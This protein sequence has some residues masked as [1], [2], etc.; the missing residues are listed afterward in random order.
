M[1]GGLNITDSYKEESPSWYRSVC[2]IPISRVWCR[3]CQHENQLATRPGFM[4]EVCGITGI[5]ANCCPFVIEVNNKIQIGHNQNKYRWV[6]RG[7]LTPKLERAIDLGQRAIDLGQQRQSQC[8]ELYRGHSQ[9][10]QHSAHFLCRSVS[11]SHLKHR[12]LIVRD[13]DLFLNRILLGVRRSLSGLSQY[14][15]W[16][17]CGKSNGRWRKQG[18]GGC[19]I[20]CHIQW[21]L[22]PGIV[23]ILSYPYISEAWRYTSFYRMKFMIKQIT[24]KMVFRRY[25]CYFCDDIIRPKNSMLV[26]RKKSLL[27]ESFPVCRIRMWW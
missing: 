21:K 8:S 1:L 26:R 24:T 14:Q 22:F 20:A 10:R 16:K 6:R 13:S 2:M 9:V 4:E 11:K 15:S 17:Q 27:L 3:N 12:S 25:R 7:Q 19:S 18:L 23:T 5:I